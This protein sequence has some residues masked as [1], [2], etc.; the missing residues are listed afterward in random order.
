MLMSLFILKSA[1][2]L[3]LVYGFYSIIFLNV[4]EQDIILD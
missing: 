4:C 2:M 1:T 3:F